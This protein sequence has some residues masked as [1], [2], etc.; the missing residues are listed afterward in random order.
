[1]LKIQFTTKQ[2]IVFCTQ[3][4]YKMRLEQIEAV[5]VESLYQLELIHISVH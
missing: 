3:C 5:V 2:V 1:M 4:Y